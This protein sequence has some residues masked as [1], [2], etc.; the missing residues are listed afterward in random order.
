MFCV[1]KDCRRVLERNVV[2]YEELIRGKKG[3]WF[4][5]NK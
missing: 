1:K 4:T 3:V 5:L 2:Y